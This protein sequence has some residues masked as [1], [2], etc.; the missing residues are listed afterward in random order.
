MR[1][2]SL[3][4]LTNTPPR[5]AQRAPGGMQGNSI[6]SPLLSRAA[7]KLGLDDVAIHRINAPEGRADLESPTTS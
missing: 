6:M 7:R 1:W 2:R 4:V 5:G 3:S